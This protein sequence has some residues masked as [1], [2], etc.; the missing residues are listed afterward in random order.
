MGEYVLDLKDGYGIYKSS[1][2]CVYAGYW[3]KGEMHGLGKYY[4]SDQK[5]KYGLWE[6]GKQLEWFDETI[7]ENIY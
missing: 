3:K 6:N 7:V 2:G 1:N 4:T 5:E